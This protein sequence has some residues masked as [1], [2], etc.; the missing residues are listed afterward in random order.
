[1]GHKRSRWSDKVC[2]SQQSCLVVQEVPF[3]KPQW[4][5]HEWKDQCPWND[6]VALEKFLLWSQEVRDEDSPRR[7]LR[8]RVAYIMLYWGQ[9]FI[10]EEKKN[11]KGAFCFGLIGGDRTDFMISFI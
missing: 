3:L 5:V 2:L 9:V 7:L 1:M 4:P 10:Q 8:C 6:V 11:I